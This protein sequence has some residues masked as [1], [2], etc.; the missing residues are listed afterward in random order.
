MKISVGSPLSFFVR[1]FLPSFS[2]STVTEQI[3]LLREEL[4]KK[5]L[6]P[7]QSAL[8]I[9]IGFRGNNPF[10]SKW[11]ANANGKIMTG[12]IH[13][14]NRS[15]QY[16]PKNSIE[17]VGLVLEQ[18]DGKL[19]YLNELVNKSFSDDIV[20]SQLT[21]LQSHLLRL[22]EMTEFFLIYSRKFLIMMLHHEY[23]EV[24]P[25]AAKQ[26]PLVKG[27][28]VWVEKRLSAFIQMLEIYSQ[29]KE[30]FIRALKN[31]PDITIPEETD[32]ESLASKV[33]GKN[34]DPLNLGFIP[35]VFNPIY[36]I[37]NMVLL[38]RHSRIEAAKQE[39]E[40][41]ELR[42]QQYRMKLGGVDN[43]KMESVV[44]NAEERLKRLNK[45]I[46]DMEESYAADYG[47]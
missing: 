12:K 47:A 6:P 20:N 30:D 7:Y 45:K 31:V 8:D 40:Y 1:T 23:A 25:A 16:V 37:R 36:H 42:I 38:W 18:L 26:A 21:Y 10:K 11:A 33:H 3:D 2:K 44:A 9:Q 28:V 19:K 15:F 43:A 46:A 29:D 39:R 5:T 4:G 27:D 22:V 41:L 32:G 13:L 24:D 34:L 14:K 35:Y 17:V